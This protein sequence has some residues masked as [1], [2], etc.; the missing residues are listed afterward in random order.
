MAKDAA[1]QKLARLEAISE[2]Q[3]P[4]E[5]AALVP[6]S[7]EPEKVKDYIQE[8]IIPLKDRLSTPVTVGSPTQPGSPQSNPEPAYETFMRM[9]DN[10]EKDKYY[11]EH[12]ADI[13]QGYNANAKR[14]AQ[15]L[16]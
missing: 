16:R 10:A 12:K 13:L 6:E 3:L 15:E 4:P 7:L 5:L 14:L 11:E 9:P 2:S 1:E 8:R